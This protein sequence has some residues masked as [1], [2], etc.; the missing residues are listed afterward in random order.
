MSALFD[1]GKYTPY[2]GAAYG[3]SVFVIA[4]L[5]LHR[6]SKLAKAREAERRNDKKN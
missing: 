5:I 1:F 6:R 4:A 2:I 3:V